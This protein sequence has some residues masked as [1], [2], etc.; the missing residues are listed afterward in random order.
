MSGFLEVNNELLDI[1]E[2]IESLTFELNAAREDHLTKKA[3]YENEF[4]RYILETKVKDPDAT[5]TD[6]KAMATN[7][8]HQT[9]M[10]S[11]RADSNYHRILNVLK[12]R[13]DRL[14]ALREVSY[15]LRKEAGIQ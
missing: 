15:N 13:H 8:A 4:S 5:Q 7:L 2:Q 9:R 1:T 11:I 6:I 14:D 12:A 10:E 3:I